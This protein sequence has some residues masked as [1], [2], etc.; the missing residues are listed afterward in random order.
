MTKIPFWN[1]TGIV[2]GNVNR[3]LINLLNCYFLFI[4]KYGS[5]SWTLDKSLKEI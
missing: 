5:K 1:I 3:S 2:K 4:L